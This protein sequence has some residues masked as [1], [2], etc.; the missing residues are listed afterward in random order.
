[1]LTGIRAY[2]KFRIVLRQLQQFVLHRDDATDDHGA[3]G[4]DDGLALEHLWE[5]V[6]HTLG[7]LPVL[8]GTQG[9]QFTITVLG[10]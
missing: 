8:R 7:N 1:M 9:C 10:L 6:V 2:H 3:L 5:V 4:V